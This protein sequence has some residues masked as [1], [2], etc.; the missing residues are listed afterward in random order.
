MISPVGGFPA[1]GMGRSND[2]LERRLF[3]AKGN[4]KSVFTPLFMH[5][6]LKSR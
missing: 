4:A 2:L 1:V 6:P 5:L 3:K